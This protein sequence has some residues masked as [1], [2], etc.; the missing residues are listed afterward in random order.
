MVVF[1]GNPFINWSMIKNLVLVVISIC[2]FITSDSQ[3]VQ[4]AFAVFEK[5][6]QVKYASVSLYVVEANSGKV[7][8]DK[9]SRMGLAPA[10]TLKI[11]T[12]VTA[13]ELLGKDYRY[14]TAFG[15]GKTDPSTLYIMP[16]GDPSFGS[17][18]WNATKKDV[19]LNAYTTSLQQAKAGNFKKIVIDNSGWNSETIPDGWI[20]QD[21]G[22]YYGAGAAKFNWRENQVD[23]LLKSG[24]KVGDSVEIVGVD[25]A[26]HG[27]LLGMLQSEV[28]S[29]PAGSG[30][31]AYVYYPVNAGEKI[32]IRGTI[33]VNENRFRISASN[34]SV[35]PLTSALLFPGNNARGDN[36]ESYVASKP[37]KDDVNPSDVI[38]FHSY[39]SPGM[40]SLIY[41]FNKRSINLYGEALV[42]T[43]SYEKYKLART[44]S[45]VS[46]MRKFWKQK[47]IDENE[48]NISDGSGLSPLNRVTTHAQV[49]ILK[50]ARHQPWFDLFYDALP[51]FNNM[52]MKSGTIS[53]VKGFCGYNTAK[54]GKTYI[55]SFLV[56]NYSGSTSALV[57][58]MF[59]VLDTLK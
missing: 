37:V 56:N 34:Y 42:K 38:I 2:I 16:S 36:G 11:I 50:Y 55:F 15:Y 19:V 41:W 40:D 51:E 54:N 31:N 20:W 44:D 27:D 1:L 35:E 46:I 22:N 14:R 39:N 3:N 8:F 47:G 6:P 43:F 52:K 53:D 33:P 12:S 5:D 9:N 59:K 21:L 4:K 48:L 30:D 7:V 10:S 28:T 45:G 23:I 32:K 49:E 13:F 29:G 18:R 25:P 57:N 17:W 58:K 26:D 24:K